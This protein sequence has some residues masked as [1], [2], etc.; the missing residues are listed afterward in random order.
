MNSETV[1]T[2]AS[3]PGSRM[4]KAGGLRTLKAG[5]HRVSGYGLMA[6]A[7]TSKKVATSQY[8]SGERI[9]MKFRAPADGF[10]A[11]YLI[12]GDDEAN[13]LL[14]YP[15]DSDGRFSISG[16]KDYNLFDKEL[17]PAAANYKLT[18][19]RPLEDNQLVI[20]YSPHPF[21]KCNDISRDPRHPNVIN[22]HDFQKWLLRI[23]RQDRDMVVEK[24][25][26]RIVNNQ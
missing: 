3:C 14:P 20:I 21:V 2:K 19:N 24:K 9:Y 13:C 23:Q 4:K 10:L 8:N 22:T 17:D 1:Y 16:G 15:K 12:V 25:Y 7:T 18:T 11:V 5:I 6:H 26:V